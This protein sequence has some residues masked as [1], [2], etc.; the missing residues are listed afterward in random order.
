MT[1]DELRRQWIAALESNQ[2]V[3]GQRKLRRN[4]FSLEANA[5]DIPSE[6]CCL[7]VLCDLLPE[8]EGHWRGETFMDMDGMTWI[9]NPPLRAVKA[10]GLDDGR[11]D[12]LIHMNDMEGNSFAEIASYLRLLWDIPVENQGIPD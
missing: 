5:G 10:V 6:F 2:Y 9:Q 11:A 8:A 7:G 3:Q 12:T 4:H 1:Q